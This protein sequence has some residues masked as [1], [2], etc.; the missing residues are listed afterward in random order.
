MSFALTGSN[1]R[2]E[3]QNRLQSLAKVSQVTV[4]DDIVEI[5]TVDRWS[6]SVLKN[7][8]EPEIDGFQVDVK[9]KRAR[10]GTRP[11][12]SHTIRKQQQA[13][14][15]LQT[16]SG[17]DVELSYKAQEPLAAPKIRRTRPG[18]GSRPIFDKPKTP[19][20]ESINIRVDNAEQRDL[21]DALIADTVYGAPVN[22]IIA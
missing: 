6:P 7:V 4:Q 15:A 11:S 18:R 3:A 5:E 14:S 9:A 19:E 13:L 8:L 1:F 16:L 10:R 22:Y 2:P 17:G 20:F 21:A 12:R